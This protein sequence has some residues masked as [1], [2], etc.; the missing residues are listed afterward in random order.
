MWLVDCECEY[1]C[2]CLA[3]T[4]ML[5]RCADALLLFDTDM[6]CMCSVRDTVVG[7]ALL[8]GVSGGER[9]RVTIAEALCGEPQLLLLDD[10]TVC[11]NVV[12]VALAAHLLDDCVVSANSLPMIAICVH[13]T[14]GML[15]VCTLLSACLAYM[16]HAIQGLDAVVAL[17]IIKTL[18]TISRVLGCT[19]IASL[20][21]VCYS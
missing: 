6:M 7:D 1:S 15:C 13:T 11:H 5:L 17:D 18:R 21:Q 19:I 12:C 8:R 2:S 3:S 20:Y 14:E 9:K 4:S 16:T 10:C